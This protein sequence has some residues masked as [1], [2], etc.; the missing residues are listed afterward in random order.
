[1]NRIV[2][3]TALVIAITVPAVLLARTLIHSDEDQLTTIF[4]GLEQSSF[5]SLLDAAVFEA[6]GL[7]VSAGSSSRRFGAADREAARALLE[8]E[9]GIE[10]ADTVRLRQQ[11]VTV[12]DGSATAVLNVEVDDGT[13]VALRVDLTRQHDRWIVERIRVMG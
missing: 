3:Y 9:T 1:M 4:D 10:S 7:V 8:E 12:R 13:F 5:D 6:E 2:A 11:Q